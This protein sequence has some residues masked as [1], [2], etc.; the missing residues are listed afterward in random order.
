MSTSNSFY[1]R[2]LYS[3]LEFSFSALILF[4]FKWLTVLFKERSKW[5]SV[6]SLSGQA[7]RRTPRQIIHII[8]DQ[9]EDREWKNSKHLTRKQSFAIIF[10][11]KRFLVL[12][13]TIPSYDLR[14]Y[15]LLAHDLLAYWQSNTLNALV[16]NAFSRIPR[17]SLVISEIRLSSR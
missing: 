6:L 17:H 9:S 8:G 11:L 16:T 5:T 1:G 4:S 2:L 7:S 10:N 3:N 14:T 15:Y 12:L 13:V